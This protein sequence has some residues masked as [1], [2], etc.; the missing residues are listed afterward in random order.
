M[1]YIEVQCIRVSVCLCQNVDRASSLIFDHAT[2]VT[3]TTIPTATITD[4]LQV[5]L[6][7]VVNNQLIAYMIKCL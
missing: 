5:S 1:S 4:Q 7:T 6:Q 2:A 3:V